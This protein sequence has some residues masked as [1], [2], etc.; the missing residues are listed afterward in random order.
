M[1]KILLIF[2][3]SKKSNIKII[4]EQKLLNACDSTKIC[5]KNK[6]Y[7]FTCAMSR[8]TKC[9]DS[10][11]DYISLSEQILMISKPCD[12]ETLVVCTGSTFIRMLTVFHFSLLL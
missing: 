2:G 5:C 10:N 1:T 6:N 12:D 8:T 9:L 7:L 3:A 4:L 11:K